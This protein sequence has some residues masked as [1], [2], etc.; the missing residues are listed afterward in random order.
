ML[1]GP[2]H[3]KLIPVT[4]LLGA[5]YLLLIDNIARTMAQVE[6]PIGI[7]TSIV[8]VPFFLYLL[9]RGRRGWA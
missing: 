5:I 6:I 4:V 8:G 7:L 9:A 3:K 1:V 2:D